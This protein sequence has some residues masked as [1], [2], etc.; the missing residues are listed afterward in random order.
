M[1]QLRR[2]LRSLI[3]LQLYKKIASSVDFAYLLV[4]GELGLVKF[5]FFG[6]KSDASKLYI[7]KI[8]S[9]VT[10]R[11]STP[12]FHCV[13]QNIIREE[14]KAARRIPQPDLIIDAGGYIGDTT[15][16]FKKIHPNTPIIT[17]EPEI[18]NYK[19]CEKNL[20]GIENVT[21]MNAAL[22]AT[23]GFITMDKEYWSASINSD[24]LDEGSKIESLKIDAIIRDF[25]DTKHGILKMDIEGAE[26]A[27][28]SEKSASW[29]EKFALIMVETHGP[30]SEK[31]VQSF[32]ESYNYDVAIYRS[33]HVL[34]RNLK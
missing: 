8:G 28:L 29:P 27:I 6:S 23:G 2:K 5:F 22:S 14:Y 12:D 25:P 4:G 3:P 18:D 15:L 13:L 32:S 7:K 1:E 16:F 26:T 19:L 17:L 10:I 20:H 33:I 9:G 34:T 21:I 24:N 30:E 31:S 11:N